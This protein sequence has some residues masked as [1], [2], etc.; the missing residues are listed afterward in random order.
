MKVFFEAGSAT[1][2]NRLELYSALGTL[3]SF[4][5]LCALGYPGLKEET[6]E[7]NWRREH[8]Y[9]TANPIT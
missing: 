5:E 8:G 3:S 9:L 4:C 6:H 7:R 1:R 2:F